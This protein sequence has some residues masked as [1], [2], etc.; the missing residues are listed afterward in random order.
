MHPN[1]LIDHLLAV[2]V[3][4][5]LIFSAIWF[6]GRWRLLLLAVACV[7]VIAYVTFYVARPVLIADRVKEDV[8]ILEAYLEEK[9]PQE[10]FTI[11]TIPFRTEGYESK[12]PYTI[13][14]TF[15]SEPD[16][17]YFYRVTNQDEV[18]QRGFSSTIEE[19]MNFLH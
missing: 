13:Y 17:E 19:K 5:I 16:A 18:T 12:N 2:L 15:S 11:K 10:T 9:Y 4:T 14:V 3:V 1:E 7:S 8:V 6:R